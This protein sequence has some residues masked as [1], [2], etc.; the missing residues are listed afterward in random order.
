MGA[1]S[2]CIAPDCEMGLDAATPYD[3]MNGVQRCASGHANV[4]NREIIDVVVELWNR[5]E[6]LEQRPTP[7]EEAL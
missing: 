1:Y 2:Y 5:V 6:E 3:I 4:P 7:N